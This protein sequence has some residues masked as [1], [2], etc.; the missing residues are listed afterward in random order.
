M[1]VPLPPDL[2][3]R[4]RLA[5]RAFGFAT[6]NGQAAMVARSWDSRAG[7]VLAIVAPFRSTVLPWE[8][9]RDVLDEQAGRFES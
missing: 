6:L 7:T 4:R 1:T 9:I 2:T 8:E 5:D 3:A